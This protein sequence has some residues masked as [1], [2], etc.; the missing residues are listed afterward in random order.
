MSFASSE[1]LMDDS[2]SAETPSI[3]LKGTFKAGCIFIG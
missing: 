1:L 3:V 2:Y